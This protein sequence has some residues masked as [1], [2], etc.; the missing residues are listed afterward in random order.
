MTIRIRAHHDADGIIA[1]YFLSFVVKD[2]QLEIWDGKFGDTTGLKKGDYMVDMRP[3]QNMEGLTVYDHHTP[4]REDHK[5]ELIE[6][7]VPAGLIVWNKHKDDIPKSEWWKLAIS[8]LGDGQ[9]ELIPTEVFETCPQLLTKIKTSTYLNYGKWNIGY[10]PIYKLLSSYVNAL[11]RLKHYED[12]INLVTYSQTPMN[13][14]NSA[15]AKVCKAEIKRIYEDIIKTSESYDFEDLVV[16]IFDSEFRMSGYIASSLQSSV[17]NKTIMAINRKDGSGS[18]RG[19]LAMYWRDK[20]KHLEYLQIDGHPG[21][22]GLNISC[23]PETLINDLINL[24]K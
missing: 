3:I 15:K 1:G 20:L 14:I 12:A 17:D 16:F 21:F 19:D 23:N 5:Y 8:L 18:V 7:E 24:Q 11:L 22:M 10:Y 2:P 4:H 9:P 13:I 6:D